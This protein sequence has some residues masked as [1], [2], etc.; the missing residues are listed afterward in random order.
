MKNTARRGW[1]KRRPRDGMAA[2]DLLVN[3]GLAVGE[4][5]RLRK[6]EVTGGWVAEIGD[7]VV[8]TRDTPVEA[9][10]TAVQHRIGA[11]PPVPV[12]G[13]KTC[14][15]PDEPKPSHDGSKS[16]ESGSIASGGT[17]S[18]CACDVCF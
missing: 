11:M 14:A 6:G 9:V 16:C 13:C 15:L 7:R 3:F 12:R 10:V 17:R 8:V 1:L 2:T 5:T 4:Q 18:H